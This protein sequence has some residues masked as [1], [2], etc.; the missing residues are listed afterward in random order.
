MQRGTS[1]LW[2]RVDVALCQASS[3]E[4]TVSEVNRLLRKWVHDLPQNYFNEEN[5]TIRCEWLTTKE[6][7]IFTR[8]H[9][10]ATPRRTN[11]PILVAEYRGTSYMLDGTNR[12]NRWL[13]D[14]SAEKHEA[15]ILTRNGE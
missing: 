12:I 9:D 3:R 7:T 13:K 6:L 1:E 5:S 2:S 4:Q 10:R 11:G 15:I 8:G 14:G